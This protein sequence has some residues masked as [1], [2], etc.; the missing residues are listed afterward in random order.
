MA[1]SGRQRRESTR[2]PQP[3][4]RG[5]GAERCN[6]RRRHAHRARGARGDTKQGQIQSYLHCMC[7][8]ATVH[9]CMSDGAHV[10]LPPA[11][12]WAVLQDCLAAGDQ[13]SSTAARTHNALCLYVV[14][15]FIGTASTLCSAAPGCSCGQSIS[16]PGWRMCRA[17]RNT[18]PKATWS[19]YM[20]ASMAT[21]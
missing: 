20:P 6:R 1:L 12:G 18:Q 15:Q 11:E 5:R 17:H 8:T 3:N 14:T 13:L 4:V 2:A 9:T 10:A 16:Q 7:C 21:P 19:A